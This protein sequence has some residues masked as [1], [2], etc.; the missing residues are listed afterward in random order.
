MLQSIDPFTFVH[1]TV[2]PGIGPHTFGS[3]V[4]KA[5]FIGRAVRITFKTLAVFTVVLPVSL[6]D[7]TVAVKQDSLALSLFIYY[8]TVI[9]AVFVFSVFSFRA[10][11]QLFQREVGYRFVLFEMLDYTFLV[12]RLF[13]LPALSQYYLLPLK[14]I[15]LIEFRLLS[16]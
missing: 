15:T 5:T 2:G 6:I 13:E 11:S 10:G 4:S 8:L 16:E 7:T 14:E 12:E 9:D 1:F 3:V